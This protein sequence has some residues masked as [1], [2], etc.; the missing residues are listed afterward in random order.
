MNDK[1]IYIVDDDDDDE[2]IQEAVETLGM[3]NELKFFHTAED[4]LRELQENKTVPFIIISDVNLPKMDG[5]ELREKILQQ[6]D[7]TDKSM[8]FIFWSTS[9]SEAQ[10]KRAYDLSA[11][12][13]FIKNNTFKELKEELDEIIKYWSKSLVPEACK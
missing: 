10:I 7:I 11:H 13:F 8:P 4:L 5:F 9:A 1:P 12:G 3:N 2:L 6:T